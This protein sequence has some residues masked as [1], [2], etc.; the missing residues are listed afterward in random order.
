MEGVL[1]YLCVRPTNL[2]PLRELEVLWLLPRRAPP[3]PRSVRS[4]PCPSLQ[5]GG[6]NPILDPSMCASLGLIWVWV[7]PHITIFSAATIASPPL[8]DIAVKPAQDADARHRTP[9]RPPTPCP[10]LPHTTLSTHDVG[11]GA[12]AG[13]GGK[14]G[15]REMGSGRG[16][17]QGTGGRGRGRGGGGGRRKGGQ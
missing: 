10:L 15:D 13:G 5:R 7:G 2:A 1:H 3:P 8:H 4:E 16:R 14:D 17:E 11:G 6:Q 12:C 9:C